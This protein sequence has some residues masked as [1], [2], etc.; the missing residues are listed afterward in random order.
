MKRIFVFGG[1]G[2]VSIYNK[3]SIIQALNT[4]AIKYCGEIIEINQRGVNFYSDSQQNVCDSRM[5]EYFMR[6]GVGYEIIFQDDSFVRECLDFI[7]SHAVP[8]FTLY[9]PSWF[10][11]PAE[12][13]TEYSVIEV[14]TFADYVL[15]DEYKVIPLH[16]KGEMIELKSTD[17]PL[18]DHF[19]LAEKIKGRPDYNTLFRII[20]REKGLPGGK[21][22]A[23][24]GEGQMIATCP[25]I[26]FRIIYTMWIM[27]MF[28]PII[29]DKVLVYSLLNIIL[30]IR[31]IWMEFLVM[32]MLKMNIPDFCQ[33]KWDL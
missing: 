16:E 33:K 28:C 20:V 21:I 12:E 2:H 9:V 4:A 15:P 30:I 29:E 19:S 7:K 3:S 13:I 14:S 10:S 26:F 11:L 1:Y 31:L 23:Y 8:P 25:A 6:D 17:Q 18:A 27:F 22:Y 32:E 5:V 24:I